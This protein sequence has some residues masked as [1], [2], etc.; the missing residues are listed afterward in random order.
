[1]RTREQ[2]IRYNQARKL[3]VANESI[4]QKELRRKARRAR[5][6]CDKQH[7]ANQKTTWARNNLDKIRNCKLKKK[8]GWTIEDYYEQLEKQDGKCAICFD[9]PTD[10]RRL[11]T[12]HCHKNGDVRGLLCSNC[13]TGLGLFRDN[14]DNLRMALYYLACAGVN[15]YESNRP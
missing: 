8:F 14:P 9:K 3:V 7:L 13:N 15:R 11:G 12:D 1:M 4:E 2:E 6:A 10:Q 5:Y